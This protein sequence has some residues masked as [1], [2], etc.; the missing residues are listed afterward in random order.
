MARPV[1]AD[2]GATKARILEVACRLLETT[3]PS[4]FS[5]R[6]VARRAGVSISMVGHHFG[7]KQGLIDACIETM[8]P[9]LNAIA[10]DLQA[11]LVA[12]AP[13]ADVLDDSVLRCYRHAREFQAFIRILNVGVIDSGDLDSRVR[14]TFEFPGLRPLA[15]ALAAILSVPELE[16][17]LRL[18]TIL[19]VVTR[20]AAG[21]DDALLELVE[22]SADDASR[23]IEAHLSGLVRALFPVPRPA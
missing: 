23:A 16:V 18:K 8:Y 2:A 11:Q 5:N 21:T 9:G 15:T 6:E 10:A 12:G 17:R 19:F 22:L 3:S 14:P 4:S 1:N 7:S 20:Y 13:L